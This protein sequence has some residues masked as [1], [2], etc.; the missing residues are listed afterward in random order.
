M[1]TI[2][3]ALVTDV[4]SVCRYSFN[5]DDINTLTDITELLDKHYIEFDEKIL[6]PRKFIIDVMAIFQKYYKQILW[7]KT[8]NIFD[9][10]SFMICMKFV[11]NCY[12]LKFKLN[13]LGEPNLSLRCVIHKLKK[14]D[15][16]QCQC[17]VCGLVIF[18]CGD[19]DH[20]YD[21]YTYFVTNITYEQCSICGKIINEE[22]LDTDKTQKS[23]NYSSL[24]SS[25]V[26]LSSSSCYS[27][28]F[29]S[30]T[31]SLS[32][33]SSSSLTTSSCTSLVL[34][35]KITSIDENN[36]KIPIKKCIPDEHEYTYHSEKT[37][38]CI[39]CGTITKINDNTNIK[40]LI[41]NSE[42]IQ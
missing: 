29:S 37:F 25:S 12:K 19:R 21:N 36:C 38:E 42:Y 26:S 18:V 7:N 24:S 17:I 40:D 41:I 28:S 11:F 4:A 39:I 22:T 2:L 9:L 3:I 5:K 13:I 20:I 14:I 16:K 27:S 33:S 31:S 1:D 34:S 23:S 8:M 6:N 15:H 30:S 35:D 10:E 32:S